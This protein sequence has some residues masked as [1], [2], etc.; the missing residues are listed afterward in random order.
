M[1]NGWSY[2]LCAI[3]LEVCGTSCM[4]ASEG[5]TRPLPSAAMFACYLASL[6]SLTMALKDIEVSVAYAIWSGLGIV[7]ITLIGWYCFNEGLAPGKI[8]CVGLIIAGV[9]GLNLL[10]GH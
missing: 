6:S 5:F 9:I 3:L 1:M 10:G 4:K 7:L 8:A 2:L